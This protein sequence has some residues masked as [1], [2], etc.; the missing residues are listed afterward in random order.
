MCLLLRITKIAHFNN[1]VLPS[2]ILQIL[3]NWY[4]LSCCLGKGATSAGER[5]Q[6]AAKGFFLVRFCLIITAVEWLAKVRNLLFPLSEQ[7]NKASEGTAQ[8]NDISLF[9]HLLKK[10]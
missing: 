4:G 2:G 8:T 5:I 10:S 6:N 3:L 1:K 9:F 7:P